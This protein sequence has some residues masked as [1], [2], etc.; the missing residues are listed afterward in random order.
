MDPPEA[1]SSASPAHDFRMPAVAACGWLAGIAAHQ[2]GAAAVLL[3]AAAGSVVVVA[4]RRAGAPLA[5]MV[6]ACVLVALGVAAVTLL[7]ADSVTHGVLPALA[8][9]RAV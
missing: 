1:A 3:V 4:A 8:S 5:R 7:R 2:V 9:E 6:V